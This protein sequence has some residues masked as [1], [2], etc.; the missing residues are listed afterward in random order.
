MV[1]PTTTTTIHPVRYPTLCTALYNN[2]LAA[3]DDVSGNT[4]NDDA[5][6]CLVTGASR[7]IGKCIALELFKAR[8]NVKIIVN[9]IESMKEEMEKVR[10]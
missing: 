5:K 4:T 9:D 10:H 3:D 6:V 2:H 7:G 1:N 8:K